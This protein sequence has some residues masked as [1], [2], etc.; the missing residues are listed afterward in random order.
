MNICEFFSDYMEMIF[1][2]PLDERQKEDSRNKIRAGRPAIFYA[3][4]SKQD[5]PKY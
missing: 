2:S 3:S 5:Q 1:D 4:E